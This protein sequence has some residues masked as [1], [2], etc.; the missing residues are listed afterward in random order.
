[1]AIVQ[2]MVTGKPYARLFNINFFASNLL[3]K[4]DMHTITRKLLLEDE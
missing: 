1:V 4:D 3:E 2:A